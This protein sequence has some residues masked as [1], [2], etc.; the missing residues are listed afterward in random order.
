MVKLLIGEAAVIAMTIWLW[1]A[2]PRHH[3]GAWGVSLASSLWLLRASVDLL[4]A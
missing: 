3:W 2:K 4:L 1:K